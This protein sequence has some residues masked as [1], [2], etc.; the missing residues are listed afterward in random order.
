MLIL[1]SASD[2]T[3]VMYDDTGAPISLLV[4][5]IPTKVVAVEDVVSACRPIKVNGVDVGVD[6]LESSSSYG[7]K[8]LIP[9]DN[10][11]RILHPPRL[12]RS[13]ACGTMRPSPRMISVD[14]TADKRG[15]SLCDLL[16][17]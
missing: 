7:P 2:S 1:E 14:Y 9:P 15:Q 5:E 6:L 4:P 8:L 17:L 3:R 11:W 12:C 13:L 16:H 10:H